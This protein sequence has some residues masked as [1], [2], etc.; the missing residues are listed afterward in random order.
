[1]AVLNPRRGSAGQSR[2][3]QTAGIEP[4]CLQVIGA[5]HLQLDT[6]DA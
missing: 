3:R 6:A 1:M 2:R 5:L 4:Q